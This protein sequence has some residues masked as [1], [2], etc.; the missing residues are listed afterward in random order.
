MSRIIEAVRRITAL[1]PLPEV[2][3]LLTRLIRDPNSD[4]EEIAVV[5]RRDMDLT[6]SLLR[7]CNSASQRG[8]EP[9]ESVDEAMMRLGLQ[10]VLEIVMALTSNRI[11]RLPPEADIHLRGLWD[12]ALLTAT[13]TRELMQRTEV[14][15]SVSFTAGLLHDI[16]KVFLIKASPADYV[17]TLRRAR[18]RHRT[19]V[20][21][22]EEE[23]GTN[24]ATV[25]GEMLSRWKLP[26]SIVTGVWFHHH[27]ELGGEQ[28]SLARAVEVAD[29]LSYATGFGL[30]D[31]YA[32]CPNT[33][34]ILEELRLTSAEIPGMISTA[35]TEAAEI[36]A[37]LG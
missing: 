32:R 22:E 2:L 9:V 25:G 34:R 12:H 13:L 18:L 17:Q 33:S 31:Q 5:V 11:Y 28:N 36:R 1:A 30:A 26:A 8:R 20:D 7:R 23:F 3:P 10:S 27:S 24:H 16:G 35:L 15:P 29:T 19:A 4:L 37:S 6:A 14:T 21:Q